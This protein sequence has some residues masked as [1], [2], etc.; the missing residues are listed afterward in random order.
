MVIHHLLIGK[1][2]Q[3]STSLSAF[4][5]LAWPPGSSWVI[6]K[7]RRKACVCTALAQGLRIS[8]SHIVSYMVIV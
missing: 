5:R 7:R 4:L 3:K 6:G 2:V 8:C 1:V